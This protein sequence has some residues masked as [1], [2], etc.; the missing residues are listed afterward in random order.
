M[1]ATGAVRRATIHS[2]VPVKMIEVTTAVSGVVWG[3]AR[4]RTTRASAKPRAAAKARAGAAVIAG[5]RRPRLPH[6]GVLMAVASVIAP[7]MAAPRAGETSRGV[8][9]LQ[10]SV[11]P[12]DGVLGRHALDALGEHVADVGQRR[13]VELRVVVVDDDDVG[14]RPAL[15]GRRGPGLDVV[16]VDPLDRDLHPGLSAKVLG[17]G[18]EHGV[19]GG[20]EV[21]PFQ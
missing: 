11:R 5:S 20:D 14:A 16:L 7:S 12:P 1:S 21:R 17:L 19:G 15:D 9:A 18:I 3:N 8:D 6:C 13:L 2:T 10:F 4:L